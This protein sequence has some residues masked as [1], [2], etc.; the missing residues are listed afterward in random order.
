M[1]LSLNFTAS[2]LGLLLTATA[3]PL[4]N[5]GITERSPVTTREVPTTHVL[6]ER[7]PEHWSAHWTKRARVPSQHILPM[8]IGIKHDDAVLQLG[9][10]RLMAQSDPFDPAYGQHMTAEEVIDF[11]APQQD[12]VDSVIDWLVESGVSRERIGHS[13]NKQWVQFDASAE[14][15]EKLLFAEFWLWEHG[16]SGGRDLACEEYHLPIGVRDVVDYVTPGIRMRPKRTKSKRTLLEIGEEE[17]EALQKRRFGLPPKD[18]QQYPTPPAHN[19][20]NCDQFVRPECLRGMR[21]CDIRS[22]L[23][24]H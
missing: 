15:V 20:T 17:A 1:H 16:E 14:E 8:R 23:Q 19:L 18:D 3:S 9:H 12:D 21:L 11:F 10:D 24:L 7:Q 5:H 4:T 6:H 13:V 2:F 22:K